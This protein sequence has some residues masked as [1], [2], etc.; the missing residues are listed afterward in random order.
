MAIQR[1]SRENLH[2]YEQ[3]CSM[4][5]STAVEASILWGWFWSY[6]F[7]AWRKS[8]RNQGKSRIFNEFLRHVHHFIGFF[9]LGFI[10]NAYFLFRTGSR[11]IYLFLKRQR[12]S[13]TMKDY[14]I[15]IYINLLLS[16]WYLPSSLF[17]YRMWNI[18]GFSDYEPL[19]CKMFCHIPIH[20][21]SDSRAGI[22]EGCSGIPATYQVYWSIS[23]T[24]AAKNLLLTA[25][26]TNWSVSYLGRTFPA[27][28]CWETKTYAREKLTKELI[29]IRTLEPNAFK[30]SKS[31][32]EKTWT[33][34]KRKKLFNFQVWFTD[35]ILQYM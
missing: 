27:L 29:L 19:S 22:L 20:L 2:R 3:P 7:K 32:A 31:F 11:L 33:T 30:M 26:M 16:Y 34:K 4:T 6:K 14:K 21:T 24:G 15:I 8:W 35:F 18:L 13:H 25:A 23:Q 1:I 17:P 28:P 9:P 10:M 5:P 12:K